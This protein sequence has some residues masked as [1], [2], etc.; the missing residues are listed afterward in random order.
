MS[1]SLSGGGRV[2][3]STSSLTAVG[4]WERFSFRTSVKSR[5]RTRA[6]WLDAE[7]L[8]LALQ[9]GIQRGPGSCQKVRGGLVDLVLSS[10]FVSPN[11]GGGVKGFWRG[12]DLLGEGDFLAE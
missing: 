10:S 12:P 2:I 9:L 8:E 6:G 7:L 5:F 4:N 1:R 3:F 11:P